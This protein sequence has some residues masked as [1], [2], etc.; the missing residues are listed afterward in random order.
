M[1]QG[2]GLVA[3]KVQEGS[4]LDYKRELHLESRDN[5]LEALKDLS[6]MGNGGGGTVLFGV[7]EAEGSDGVPDRIVPL[8]DRAVAGVL[9]D[10]TRASVGPPLLA[11]FRVVDGVGGFVLAVEVLRSPLGPY[12]VEAY[13]EH[14]YHVRMGTRTV[15]MPERQVQDAN[16]AR[17][18]YH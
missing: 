16:R 17:A 8:T 13:G 10:I 12:M 11:T 15:P 6:G 9:E 2:G 18:P 4:S 7:S 5:R 14:R 3:S 1:G